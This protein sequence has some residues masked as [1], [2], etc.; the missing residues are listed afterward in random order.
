VNLAPHHPSTD[1]PADVAA[2]AR[3]H[4]YFNEQFLDPVFFGRYPELVRE[5]Y[6][7]AW[8][9]H[10][11]SELRELMEPI[12]FLG[13][14]C[15]TG[16]DVKDDPAKGPQRCIEV[17]VTNEPRMTTGWEVRPELLVETLTWVTQRYGRIP[18]YVTENGAAFPDP[19]HASGGRVDDPLRVDYLRRHIAAMREAM[20]RGVDLRGYFVW[21]LMDNFEWASGYLHRMGL[22]HVDYT[23]QQ[24]TVKASGEFYARVIRENGVNVAD[25]LDPSAASLA[26]RPG[27]VQR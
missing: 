22:L 26:A 4:A 11:E 16:Y 1:S 5:M 12:D 9:S 19:D 24:R 6:G 20:R 23:T 14:N 8:P 25:S 10:P 17:P 27:G 3:G 13:I 18:L 15:Y 2:A 21:S 7:D